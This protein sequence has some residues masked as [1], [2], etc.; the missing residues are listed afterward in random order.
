MDSYGEIHEG[1]DQ[2]IT[3]Y[4]LLDDSDAKPFQYHG[5]E[6]RF[7]KVDF[8]YEKS[9]VFSD[10]SFTIK[11]GQKVGLVG[12]SGAG[13]STLVQLLL[14]QYDINDGQILFDDQNI[15][16]VTQDSLRGH[17]AF[18]PQDPVL[19]HR[20]LAENIG[21][22]RKDA[23]QDEIEQ[24]AELAQ[25]HEFITELPEWYKTLVGERGVKLSGGQ[26]QRIIIARAILKNAPILVLDEAT[27]ALDSESEEKIQLALSELMKWKT[28]IAI[29]HRLSTIKHLDRILVFD[30]WKIVED[31]SHADLSSSSGVY[32]KL[33]TKQVGWFIGE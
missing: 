11:P 2:I 32:G 22:G 5:G 16:H 19:F 3:D 26:R 24:A 28:V 9:S 7:D 20:T 12:E 8:A 23:T 29:A 13:K 33:W 27:S 14:R 15:A 31:G 1:L 17:I 4:N 10:L 30:Q 6:I 18:V 21:Y 25:A